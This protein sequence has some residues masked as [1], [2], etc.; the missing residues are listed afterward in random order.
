MTLHASPSHSLGSG[1]PPVDISSGFALR[2][3]PSGLKTGCGGVSAGA[4]DVAAD[5]G[6]GLGDGPQAASVSTATLSTIGRMHPPGP[7][8]LRCDVAPG[9]KSASLRLF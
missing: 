1:A 2:T 4:R 3:E 9:F 6:R 8:Q 5:A 7:C